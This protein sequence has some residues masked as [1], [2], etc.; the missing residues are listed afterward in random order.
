MSKGIEEM[1]A[2]HAKLGALLDDPAEGCHTWRFAI[3]DVLMELACYAGHGHVTAFPDLLKACKDVQAT[4][5]AFFKGCLPTTD[6]TR[7]GRIILKMQKQVAA[8]IRKAEG[9]QP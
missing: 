2:L 9:G 5:E 4:A 3:S 8:A 1:K 6:T 7:Y